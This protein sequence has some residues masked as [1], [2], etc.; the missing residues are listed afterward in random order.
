[1]Y[2]PCYEEVARFAAEGELGPELQK[3]KAEFTRR[4]GEMFETDASFERRIAAFLEWYVL[5]RKLSFRPDLTPAELYLLQKGARLTED[6]R[7]RYAG[8]T[9][10]VLSLFEF[11]RGKADR[12]VL[13]DLLAGEKVEVFERRK[14]AGLEPGDIL[15]ARV[16]PYED[17]LLVADAYAC[18]PRDARKEILEAAKRH[19]KTA[20]DAMAARIDFVHR[21]A[22]FATRSERYKHLSPRQ[23]FAELNVQAA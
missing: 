2:Q 12:L 1:M 16:V 9:R 7:N 13:R 5:D 6:E 23:V 17:L 8:L 14:P 18:H 11:K 20:G 4:T 10:T 21:V 15:E 19:R 22:Y 3:A